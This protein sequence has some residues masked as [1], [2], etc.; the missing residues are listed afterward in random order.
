MTGVTVWVWVWP[1]NPDPTTLSF[2]DLPWLPLWGGMGVEMKGWLSQAHLASGA[3]LPLCELLQTIHSS[4][5]SFL[6]S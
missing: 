3:L 5:A 1:L 6:A 4:Q 2:R